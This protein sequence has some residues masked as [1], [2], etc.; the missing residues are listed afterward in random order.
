M[1]IK[2]TFP[3]ISFIL[4]AVFFCE[5]P[6]TAPIDNGPPQ[7]IDPEEIIS[8]ARYLETKSDLYTIKPN[9][10]DLKSL[11]SFPN[12]DAYAP[13]WSPDMTKITFYSHETVLTF[14]IYVMSAD[15]TA[16]QQ[17]VK[18]E[19]VRSWHPVWSPDG[20]KIAF[21]KEFQNQTRQIWIMNCDGSEQERIGTVNGLEPDWSPD[22]T[23]IA[24]T[25]YSGG[26]SEIAVMNADGTDQIFLTNNEAAE[27]NPVWSPNGLKIAYSSDLEGNMDI[28][29]MDADGSIQKRISL[30]S[31]DDWT[32]DWS[33]GGTEIVFCSNVNGVNRFD[34]FIINS[35]GTDLKNLTTGTPFDTQPVWIELK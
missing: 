33:P 20:T 3:C 7:N 13:D 34:L 25:D 24:Y 35:D 4:I 27:G 19:G 31:G 28:Y 30:Q 29:T 23:K 14:A 2:L 8:F 9:G 1:A 11:A 5:K 18:I 15:G 21:S 12:I 10:T 16:L 17:L 26:D 32:P 22:G 6:S